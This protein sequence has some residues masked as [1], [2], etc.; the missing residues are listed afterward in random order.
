MGSADNKYNNEENQKEYNEYGWMCSH[1]YTLSL[2]LS[3]SLSHTHTCTHA[4]MHTSQSK[5]PLS[6]KFLIS[7]YPAT[8]DF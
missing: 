2:S 3:L 5:H 6:G 8:E 1:V 4:H 7:I